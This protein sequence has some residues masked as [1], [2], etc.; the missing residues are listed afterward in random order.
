MLMRVFLLLRELSRIMPDKAYFPMPDL[1]TN[2]KPT[3]EEIEHLIAV[4]ILE[5]KLNSERRIIKS[6]IKNLLET[7]K[8][9][10]GE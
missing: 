9:Y 5:A 2:Q 3:L 1:N 10:G 8:A 4:L 7:I 6:G